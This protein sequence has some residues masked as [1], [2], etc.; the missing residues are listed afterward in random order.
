MYPSRAVCSLTICVKYRGRYS[1]LNN[2]HSK[3]TRGMSNKWYNHYTYKP[4]INRED[5][6]KR[7]DIN[8]GLKPS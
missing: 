5:R 7:L 3:I 8:I 4:Q 6:S 2:V 1:G